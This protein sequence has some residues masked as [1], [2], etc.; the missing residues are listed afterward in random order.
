MLELIPDAKYADVMER[1]LYNNVLGSMAQDGK[2]Y[3]YVNPLEVWPQACSCNPGKHHVKAERQGWFGCACCPPNVARLLTSLNQYIYSVHG[4]TLY[5]NLYIGSESSFKL[6]GQEVAVSQQSSY[7]WEGKVQLKI[8][9]AAAAKFGIAVRIP[10]WSASAELTV[11]GESVDI[12]S[13]LEQGY[14]VIRRTWTAGDVIELSL[15]MTA[16]RIYA[17]P[18]LRAD[19][20]LTAI[21][22]GPLVYCLEEADNG[23]TLSSIS[24]DGAG[25]FTER[26]EESLLGGAVVVK[27][28]GFRIDEGSWNGGLYGS[29]KAGVTPVEVTAVPYYLWGNRGSGEMKVWVRG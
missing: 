3:F 16:T 24:L 22:R 29:M 7:P 28:D 18:Q 1:A 23:A 9:P 25:A 13:V 19:A 11:N 26:F 27:T 20:G 15:P 4:D 5:T 12:T 2:H 21:Q 10:A 14:A 8:D 17:H 6:G